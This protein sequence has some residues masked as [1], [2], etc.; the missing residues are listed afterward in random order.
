MTCHGAF[1][2]TKRTFTT[3]LPPWSR[4]HQLYI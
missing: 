2:A 4:H 1:F 3:T